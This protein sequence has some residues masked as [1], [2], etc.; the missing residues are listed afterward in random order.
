MLAGIFLRFALFV[1]ILWLVF[2]VAVGQKVIDFVTINT[3]VLVPQEAV[4]SGVAMFHATFAERPFWLL[5]TLL[6][7]VLVFHVAD[8]HA[9]HLVANMLEE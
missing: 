8:L 7:S 6:L 4:V 5:P 9:L 1:V 2:I 3:F